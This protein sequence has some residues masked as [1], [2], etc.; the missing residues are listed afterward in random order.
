MSS[1]ADIHRNKLMDL[2]D[3]SIIYEV[4]NTETL[5]KTYKTVHALHSR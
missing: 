4:C 2:E 5:E 3:T 1:K